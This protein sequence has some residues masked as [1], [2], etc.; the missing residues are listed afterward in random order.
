M[1]NAK[2]IARAAIKR[3]YQKRL[4]ENPT[5]AESFLWEA[6]RDKQLGEKFTAQAIVSGFIPD[7]WCAKLRIIIEVDGAS[8]IG[9]EGYDSWRD[10]ILKSQRIS[11][12]RFTNDQ[13]ITDRSACIAKIQK[14]IVRKQGS[15]KPHR[16]K[17]KQ[18]PVTV[19]CVCGSRAFLFDE[20]LGPHL[21][22]GKGERYP[23]GIG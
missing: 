18:A 3:V 13:V 10:K 9:R 17:I 22:S 1:R 6:L 21:M 16:K 5:P 23:Y 15:F 11:I 20:K 2:K 19:K 4:R 7:F 8:H 14:E 12:L